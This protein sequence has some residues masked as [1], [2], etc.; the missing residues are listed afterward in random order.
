[1]ESDEKRVLFGKWRKQKGYLQY[2]FL[3]L[4]LL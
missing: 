1:M 4:L 2:L 3:L